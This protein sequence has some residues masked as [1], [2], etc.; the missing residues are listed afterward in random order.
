MDYPGDLLSGLF[1]IAHDIGDLDDKDLQLLV[2]SL[3]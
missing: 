1:V 2:A 3:E